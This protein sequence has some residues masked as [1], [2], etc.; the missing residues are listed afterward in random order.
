MWAVMCGLE[1]G[2]SPLAAIGG[3]ATVWCVWDIL[4]LPSCVCHAAHVFPACLVSAVRSLPR[5]M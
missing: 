5:G 1:Q 3:I 2:V 4:K